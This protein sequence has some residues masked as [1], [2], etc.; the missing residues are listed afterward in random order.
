[1]YQQ[2]RKQKPPAHE[3][4]FGFCFPNIFPGMLMKILLPRR[5]AAPDMPIHL[6]II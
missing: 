3:S 5:H 1:M 4:T 6:F 2:E